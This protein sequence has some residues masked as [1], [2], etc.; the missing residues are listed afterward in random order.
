MSRK[1]EYIFLYR[2]DSDLPPLVLDVYPDIYILMCQH[3]TLVVYLLFQEA[4]RRWVCSSLVPHYTRAGERVRPCLSVC[5]DVEQQCPYLLPGDWT[6][7]T[8]PPGETAHPTPQYA[9]EPTF[10]CLGM[11]IHKNTIQILVYLSNSTHFLR[12]IR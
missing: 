1:G 12:K 11:Y 10:I 2:K 7:Q 6:N 3:K 9:G 5:Q 8:V 4:Y